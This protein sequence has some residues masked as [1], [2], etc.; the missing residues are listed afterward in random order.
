MLK[1][2]SLLKAFCISSRKKKT[3]FK[4][5]RNDRNRS[6]LLAANS[7]H[8][9]AAHPLSNYFNNQTQCK[10]YIEM[11]PACPIFTTLGVVHYSSKIILK[12]TYVYDTRTSYYLTN[13][14]KSKWCLTKLNFSLKTKPAFCLKIYFNL[15]Q[16]FLPN[17]IC[18]KDAKYLF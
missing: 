17:Y 11:L 1:D 4:T 2:K 15:Q 13:F 18:F 8:C 16:I 6:C 7:K 5:L 10:M 3:H 12:I 9:F 14:L